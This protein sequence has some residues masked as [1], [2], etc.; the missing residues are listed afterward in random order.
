MCKRLTGTRVFLGDLLSYYLL[1]DIAK[2]G[3]ETYGLMVRY[4]DEQ[5]SIRELTPQQE[6]V[7]EFLDKLLQG[8]VTPV[9]VQDVV[10]DWLL[11]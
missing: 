9:A 11:I 2:G 6:D 4:R 10:D 5:V 1:T 8:A 7:L 3:E